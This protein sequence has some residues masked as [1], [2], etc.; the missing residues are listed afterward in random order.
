MGMW[1]TSKHKDL[2][3]VICMSKPKRENEEKTNPAMRT[4]SAANV[5]Y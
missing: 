4:G 2:L 3:D 1:A 5:R